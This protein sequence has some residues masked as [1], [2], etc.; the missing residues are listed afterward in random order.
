[1]CTI[2]ATEFKT[3]FGK[4]AKLGQKETI[5]VTNHGKVIFEINPPRDSLIRRAESLIGCLPDNVPFD[6]WKDRYK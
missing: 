3:N 1:M 2:T 4:Y 6:A 5:Q